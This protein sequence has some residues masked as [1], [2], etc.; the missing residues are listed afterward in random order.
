MLARMR[1]WADSLAAAGIPLHVSIDTTHGHSAAEAVRAS[2]GESVL[3]HTY[4]E[5][6]MVEA[7]PHLPACMRRMAGEPEWAGL[8]SRALAAGE[9][10]EAVETVARE[11]WREWAGSASSLAWGF[12][13]EAISLWWRELLQGTIGGASSLAAA[14]VNVNANAEEGRAAPPPPPLHIWVLEDDVGFTA[15]LVELIASHAS[16]HAD[17]ITDHPRPS[18][19]LRDVCVRRRDAFHDDD[20]VFWK[21]WCWHGTCTD[22]YAE[23]VPEAARLISNEHVQRFSARF[24]DEVTARVAAGCSAWSEQLAPSLCAALDRYTLEPLC[25]AHLPPD[26]KAQFSHSARV[27]EAEYRELCRRPETRGVLLH[28]LK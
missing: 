15:P 23:A 26:P 1:E 28:A 8:E 14:P 9:T 18:Q 20:K 3:V 27:S 10:R 16:S 25:S 11:V 4:D 24:L 13:A 12:H 17:L 5:P 2:L 19:P 6:Q 21:G 22:S 7:F